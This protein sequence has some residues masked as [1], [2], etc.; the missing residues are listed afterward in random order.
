M[1][2][3][4][5]KNHVPP[6]LYNYVI[7]QNGALY[8][9]HAFGLLVAKV[10]D[11]LIGNNIPFDENTLADVIEEDYCNRYPHLCADGARDKE[12]P[13]EMAE[14]K[15]DMLTRMAAAVGI[16]AADALAKLSKLMGISCETCN[17]RHRIIRRMGKIGVR[18]T[19]RLLKETI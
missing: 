14:A 8:K 12:E 17:H 3:I 10:R 9:A 2:R 15:G 7:P 19:L 5:E 18:E 1:N 16:P 6:E 11:G 13:P 4:K